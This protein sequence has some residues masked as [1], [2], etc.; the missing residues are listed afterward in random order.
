MIPENV[1]LDFHDP[2]KPYKSCNGLLGKA[3][4]CLGVS[5]KKPIHV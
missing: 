5:T 1:V 2:L 3:L 4:H